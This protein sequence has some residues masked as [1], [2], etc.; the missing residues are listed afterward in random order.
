MKSKILVLAIKEINKS[1]QVI[2]QVFE[3]IELLIKI[4]KITITNVKYM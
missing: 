1:C 2:S 3:K 4:K